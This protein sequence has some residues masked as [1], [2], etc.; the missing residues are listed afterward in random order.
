[1]DGFGGNF[2]D[3]GLV[4][5]PGGYAVGSKHAG[6]RIRYSCAG[7]TIAMQVLSDQ[8]THIKEAH[9]I[10]SRAARAAGTAAAVFTYDDAGQ[11]RACGISCGAATAAC[12]YVAAHPWGARACRSSRTTA[13]RQAL[14]RARPTP[15]VC[16]LG[17]ACVVAPIAGESGAA[18]VFG[19]YLP[20]RTADH[21]ALTSEVRE[22]LSALLQ[23]ESEASATPSALPFPLLDLPLRSANCVTAVAEWC[24]ESLRLAR[25]VAAKTAASAHMDAAGVRPA[26]PRR[27]VIAPVTQDPYDGAAI[28]VAI[29]AGDRVRARRLIAAAL[30]GSARGD[31]TSDHTARARALAVAAA[32]LEWAE[33]AGLDPKPAWAQWDR[34]QDALSQAITAQQRRTAVW[35]VLRPMRRGKMKAGTAQQAPGAIDDTLAALDGW[36]AAQWPEPVTLE[37]AAAALGLK[38][39]TLTKRL[40]RALDL[41]FTQYVNRR[42]VA[43]AKDLLVQTG[44]S[45]AAIAK[46]VGIDDGANLARI[47]RRHEGMSPGQFRRRYKR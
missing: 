5:E 38:P 24:A 13:A 19:P 20:G 17:F 25:M 2:D 47:F 1:M 34:F 28:A 23:T 30:A 36:L 32:V 12:A 39:D 3:I 27:G 35:R 7:G 6:R 43:Y 8:D 40:Q 21:E 37:A 42:R 4:A 41:P 33:A 45:I 18:V 10:V 15:F 29:A 46:R 44:L 16:H 9:R 14:R 26:P 22:G 11:E 31:S